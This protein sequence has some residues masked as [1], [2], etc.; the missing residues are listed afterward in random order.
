MRE[1]PDYVEFATVQGPRLR[2]TAY[3]LC[4]DWHEA[5]DLTQT[6]LAKMFV[7][8]RRVATDEK[9]YAYAHRTLVNAYLAT[10]R[11]R[12]SGERPS[13]DMPEAASTGTDA[14]LRMVMLAALATLAPKVRAIIVFR[15]WADLP[16]TE[17]ARLMGCR[18]GTVKSESARGL[19]KLRSLLGDSLIVTR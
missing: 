16:I 10:K 11:R 18:N 15:Y 19:A 13:A 3:L 17:V 12:S 4:G 1:Q 6:T 9:V 7:V 2:R 8:W 5:A 14:E